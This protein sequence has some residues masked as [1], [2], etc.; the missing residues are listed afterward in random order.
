VNLQEIEHGL[1]T[2][3]VVGLFD[4]VFVFF[5]VFHGAKVMD[6]FGLC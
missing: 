2:S 1:S 3:R 4:E 6:C 5:F